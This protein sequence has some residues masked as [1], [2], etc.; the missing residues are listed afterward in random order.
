MQ[1]ACQAEI[2]RGT[3]PVGECGGF[4]FGKAANIRA[5][6]MAF[7]EASPGHLQARAVERGVIRECLSG[8]PVET[9]PT[10]RECAGRPGRRSP[11]DRPNRGPCWKAARRH[12]CASQTTA[13]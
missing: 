7:P 6:P 8:W 9:C 5:A 1:E 3:S 4:D 2:A 13:A 12:G 11:R 10:L